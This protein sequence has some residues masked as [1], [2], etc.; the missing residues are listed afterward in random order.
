MITVHKAMLKDSR[1]VA[2]LMKQKYSFRK[3]GEAEET[4]RK[5]MGQ[6]HH[7]RIAWLDAEAVGLISWRTQ[8]G[9]HHGV[10]ELVRLAVSSSVPEPREVKE[11]LFDIMVAEADSFYREHGI[12]LR[13]VFSMIHADNRHI[14]EFFQDKGMRQEAVLKNHFY[15][16]MDELVFSLFL[17]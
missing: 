5:E 2:K 8:G 15:P 3:L 7:F 4:F 10:A 17:T 11:A 13:K 12:R 6:H 14:R 1:M 16:G 9:V